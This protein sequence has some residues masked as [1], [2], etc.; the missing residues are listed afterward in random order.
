VAPLDP[1]TAQRLFVERAAAVGTRIEAGEAVRKLCARLDQLP[2]AIELAAARSPLFTVE[3]LLD[4]L[5]KRLDLFKGT[6]HIDERQRTLRAC[7]EWSNELLDAE[8]RAL[9]ARLSVFAGGCTYEAAE[10]VSGADPDTLQSLIEKS[11]V[12]RRD[13]AEPRYWMLETIRE[14]AAEQLLAGSGTDDVLDRLS[15]WVLDLARPGLH[16]GSS[17]GEP[18][19][20]A[21][22]REEEANLHVALDHLRRRD[23]LRYAELCAATTPF[24][25]AT[26][27]L[28]EGRSLLESALPAQEAPPEVRARLYWGLS[29]FAAWQGDGEGA[30]RAAEADLEIREASQD[31]RWLPHALLIVG[32]S[33]ATCG[34]LEEAVAAY[35]RASETAGEV[36]DRLAVFYALDNIALVRVLQRDWQSAVA[37]AREAVDAA[38]DDGT[39]RAGQITLALALLGAGEVDPDSAAAL[40]AESLDDAMRR[41]YPEGVAADLDL[42]AVVA[43][44]RGDGRHA[45][46]LLGAAARLR[47]PL[48]LGLDP[49][50]DVF[51]ADAR[52]AIDA[53]IGTEERLRLEADGAQLP[54]ED[55]VALAVGKPERL[56]T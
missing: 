15:D 51:V 55:A 40:F 2:L 5:G 41:E 30:L 24:W 11:L 35:E 37:A 18:E 22:L 48:G 13:E 47:A 46:R 21:T 16:F 44:Y 9:F 45:S 19:W 38:P 26:S 25:H 39:E 36:D 34:R 3:Q 20:V 49:V 1:E 28:S 43:A 29:I 6:A 56:A 14:Y 4:R 31:S 53:S 54:L 10:S 52:R 8:E 42:L 32:I 23:P 27:R 12:R 33:L 17:L 50:S 7:I